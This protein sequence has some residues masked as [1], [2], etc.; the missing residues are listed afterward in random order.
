MLV[1]F[2]NNRTEQS[3]LKALLSAVQL[4]KFTV[5]NNGDLMF[6]GYFYIADKHIVSCTETGYYGTTAKYEVLGHYN[7]CMEDQNIE[8]KEI[9]RAS[10]YSTEL[11]KRLGQYL[12]CI[13]DLRYVDLMG[14]YNCFSY[15]IFKKVYIDEP[16][17]RFCEGTLDSVKVLAIP[18][19]YNQ[20]YTIALTSS[21]P[22]YA[23]LCLKL[24][25]GIK[26]IDY[27]IG[28]VEEIGNPKNLGSL[29]FEAP[30][31]VSTGLT[32]EQGDL[33]KYNDNLYLI[34]QVDAKNKS[35][36]VVLEGDYT[37]SN[38]V[39]IVNCQSVITDYPDNQ[40]RVIYAP[41]NVDT[42][43]LIYRPEFHSWIRKIHWRKDRLPTP[44]FLGF[45]C[46]SAGKE[47]ACNVED[48]GQSLGWEDP[49]EKGTVTHSSILAWIIPWT[50]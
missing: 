32:E 1:E 46:G 44:V 39:Q 28:R 22:V 23:S 3:F 20:T 12:R 41:T 5:V 14:M 37:K 35:T 6:E 9:I 15:E 13:R 7:F 45:P 31:T 4:P 38:S 17:L 18:V 8:F 33:F 47:S 19:R 21:K 25:S 11:H 42:A 50:V 30:I 48:L 24:S 2:F 29:R 49:L 10:Y 26:R 36:L 27:N 16:T 40:E 43:S 34:L